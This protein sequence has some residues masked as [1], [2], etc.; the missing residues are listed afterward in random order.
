MKKGQESSICTQRDVSLFFHSIEMEIEQEWKL[1]ERC[2][3]TVPG[4][5]H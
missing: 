4:R 5:K 1:W 2:M 3:G